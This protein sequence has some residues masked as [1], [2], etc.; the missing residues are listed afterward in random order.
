MLVRDDPDLHVFM[1]RRNPDSVFSPNAYVFPGGAVDAADQ[2]PAIHALVR[3]I[4]DVRASALVGT[5]SGGLR[6]WVAAARESFEEAGFVLGTAGDGFAA[7]REAMNAGAVSWLEALAAHDACLHLDDLLVFAHWL[8][9]EGAPRR[10]DTWFFA[11]AAPND[12]HGEHDDA[13]AVDSEWLR[14]ADALQ[15]C[16]DGDIE[17]IVPTIC[18]LRA[19]ARFTRTADLLDAVRSGQD[20]PPPRVVR[21]G[22]GQRVWLPGDDA[23]GVHNGWPPIDARLDVDMAFERAF[24]T[25][26]SPEAPA[27]S[28]RGVA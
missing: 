6:Y 19:L 8:T 15:R 28:D 21:E 23:H 16:R 10:Y 11:A 14:P 7:T 25:G 18:S 13:E 22:S 12:Q 26:E 2:D 1:L 20:A 27:T 17:L 9:P 4:D 24:L 5:T 3:G